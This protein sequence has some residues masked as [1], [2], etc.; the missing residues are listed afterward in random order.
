[1]IKDIFKNLLLVTKVQKLRQENLKSKK[2]WL[3]ISEDPNIVAFRLQIWEWV[4]FSFQ[5]LPEA[6]EIQ[7]KMK[8]QH[9]FPSDFKM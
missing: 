3:D 2:Q 5:E 8:E 1:M 6:S 9:T 7:G 4:G